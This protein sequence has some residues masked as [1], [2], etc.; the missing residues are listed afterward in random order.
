[1]DEDK[2]QRAQRLAAAL[3]ANLHR[4]KHQTRR[5]TEDAEPQG[6]GEP[7]EPGNDKP[8]SDKPGSDRPS[9]DRDGGET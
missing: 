9:S 6:D 8:G 2:T 1:L 4:R 7:H 5:R 3:R